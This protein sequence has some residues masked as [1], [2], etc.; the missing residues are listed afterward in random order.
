MQDFEIVGPIRNSETIARG[1]SVDIRRYLNEKYGVGNWR[2]RKGIALI[3]MHKS[4]RVRLAEIYW[5][6]AHGIGQRDFKR[7]HFLDEGG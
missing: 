7:K 3:Q 5:F 1:H 4:G 6:E 2:K